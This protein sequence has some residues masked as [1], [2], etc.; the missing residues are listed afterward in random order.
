MRGAVRGHGNSSGRLKTRFTSGVAMIPLL[1]WGVL[2]VASAVLSAALARAKGR[3]QRY[4]L[5]AGFLLGPIG[6]VAIALLPR[7]P[8]GEN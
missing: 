6:V 7:V 1:F 4:W 8:E 2:S 3:P 5:C